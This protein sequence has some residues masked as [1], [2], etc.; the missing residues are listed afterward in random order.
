MN[1]KVLSLLVLL[2]LAGQ[3]LA[4]QVQTTLTFSDLLSKKKSTYQTDIFGKQIKKSLQSKG[5][6]ITEA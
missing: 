3:A 6:G 5:F 1:S 4:Y 2:M